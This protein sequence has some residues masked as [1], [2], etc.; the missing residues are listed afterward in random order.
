MLGSAG[1]AAV[2]LAIP[3]SSSAAENCSALVCH[4]LRLG[5]AAACVQVKLSAC[6]RWGCRDSGMHTDQADTAA[7]HESQHLLGCRCTCKV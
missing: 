7:L 2:G 5:A 3:C 6:T 4:A 1:M